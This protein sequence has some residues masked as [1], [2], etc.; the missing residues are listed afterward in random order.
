MQE[1]NFEKQVQKKLEELNLLPSDSVW[2]KVE[3]QIREKKDRRKIFFWLIPFALLC[4]GIYFYSTGHDATI[5]K[6]N[7]INAVEVM[8]GFAPPAN[9]PLT[10]G[11]RFV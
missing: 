7:T 4:G 6:R 10:I 1:Q 9:V 11:P 3:E 5:K 8:K 2:K